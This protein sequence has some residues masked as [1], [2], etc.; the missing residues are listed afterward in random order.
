MTPI[1]QA[2][3]SLAKRYPGAVVTVVTDSGADHRATGQA[4]DET[5]LFEIGSVTKV[6]TSLALATAVTRG[7]LT[8]DT[9]LNDLL[10][11]ARLDG[12]TLGQLATH[13]SG[14]PRLPKGLL[15]RAF[16]PM[17]DPYARF[18]RD[19]LLADL[20]QPKESRGFKYSNLGAGLLGLA[21]AEH[22]G[23]DYEG[24]IRKRVTGPLGMGDT[25]I[26]PTP[27]QAGR[28]VSGHTRWGRRRPYWDL[29]ALAGAGGLRSTAADLARFVRHQL[30]GDAAVEL[31]HREHVTVNPRLSM[32]LAWLRMSA[33][34]GRQTVLWHNGGTGGFRSFMAV[35]P[36]R[37]VGVIVLTNSTRSA[38]P[39]GMKLLRALTLDNIDA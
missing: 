14:L 39:A 17:D 33:P 13:T 16:L 15:P 12:V 7:E 25:V 38:D 36:E 18:T 27:E 10:P 34:G 24:L 20:P 8:L 30:D 32:G 4:A 26:T 37:R 1:D 28:T 3:A 21:L 5:A 29:A 23:T 6:F 9:P 31:T 2:A 35:V 19:V 22:A 11:E